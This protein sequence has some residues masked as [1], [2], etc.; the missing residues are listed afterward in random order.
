[1]KCLYSVVNRVL[2]FSYHSVHLGG[3]VLHL[4]G[5]WG[6]DLGCF[7]PRCELSRKSF[8]EMEL[9]PKFNM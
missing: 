1:M 6:I 2:S 9:L 7:E 8:S 5:R 3:V 4:P